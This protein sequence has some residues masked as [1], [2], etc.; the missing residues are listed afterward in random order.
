MTPIKVKGKNGSRKR[1][2]QSPD[3]EYARKKQQ[4]RQL[5]SASGD[6]PNTTTTTTTTSSKGQRTRK[7]P[8]SIEQLPPEIIERIFL[9]SENLAFPRSS[10]LIGR[11]LSARTFLL[12]L[13]VAAFGPTWDVWFGCTR[14]QVAS[15]AGWGRDMCRFGG[16]RVFQSKVLACRWMNWEMMLDAQK[17]WFRRHGGGGRHFEREVGVLVAQGVMARADEIGECF[18]EDWA[19]WKEGCEALLY[20][21]RADGRHDRGAMKLLVQQCLRYQ[22]PYLDLHCMAKIPDYLIAGPFNWDRAKLLFWLIRGGATMNA[23]QTWELARRGFSTVMLLQDRKLIL[24]MLRLFG[25]L[26]RFFDRW[27]DHVL[28]VYM[29]LGLGYLKH[30]LLRTPRSV[31]INIAK[32]H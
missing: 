20:A 9:A 30:L 26:P 2:Y 25:S 7:G 11:M 22:S 8:A 3:P 27:P 15:Y 21:E 6:T 28:K 24:V 12:G 32:L 10:L 29:F 17:I 18:E 5:T 19:D 13:A 4:Q 16:S 14:A 1:P 31:L 23:D